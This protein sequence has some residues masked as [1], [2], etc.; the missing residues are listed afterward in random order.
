MRGTLLLGLEERGE[1]DL[2]HQRREKRHDEREHR[3]NPDAHH[4]DLI[5]E[6]VAA[7]LRGGVDG[8]RAFAEQQA[9]HDLHRGRDAMHLCVRESPLHALRKSLARPACGLSSTSA[10]ITV[11]GALALKGGRNRL[12]DRWHRACFNLRGLRGAVLREQGRHARPSVRFALAIGFLALGAGTACRNLPAAAG[13]RSATRATLGRDACCSPRSTPSSLAWICASRSAIARRFENRVRLALGRRHRDSTGSPHQLRVS[14]RRR[15]LILRLFLFVGRSSCSCIRRAWSCRS[16]SMRA[17][18]AFH[19]AGP[20]EL[21]SS[22]R[23]RR[24][25]MALVIC[26]ASESNCRDDRAL[27]NLNFGQFLLLI[28]GKRNGVLARLASL[29]F[30]DFLEIGFGLGLFRRKLRELDV[31]VPP[32]SPRWSASPRYR[33]LS[34]L[35]SSALSCTMRVSSTIG[36][37]EQLAG[38]ASSRRPFRKPPCPSPTGK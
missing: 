34:W 33:P 25:A 19:F 23:A 8:H 28:V 14:T 17:S 37:L 13:H 18:S 38:G 20:G 7:F 32:S 11:H 22:R 24:S 36:L 21:R 6:N 31:R 3:V 26:A 29:R 12:H 30:S 5:R 9:A 4:A 1:T 2:H 15:R 35:S 10:R 16:F 27:T